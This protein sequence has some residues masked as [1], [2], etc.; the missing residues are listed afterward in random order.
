MIQYFFTVVLLNDKISKK[1]FNVNKAKIDT[2]YNMHVKATETVFKA[3]ALTKVEAT[4]Y[5]TVM[6]TITVDFITTIA[7]YHLKTEGIMARCIE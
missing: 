4:E 5:D 3:K 2:S 7:K 6:F 1:E